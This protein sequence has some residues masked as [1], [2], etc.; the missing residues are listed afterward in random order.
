MYKTAVVD[1]QYLP[2]LEYFVCW[3]KYDSILIESQENFVKQTYRNRCHILSSN[4][5]LPLSIPVLGGN[6]K[7]RVKDIKIDYNQRW[8]NT[9]WRAIMSAYGRA[10]Y[11]E[12][13]ADYFESI[14]QKREKYLFDLNCQLLTL[15]LNLLGINKPLA[16]TQT[17][18]KIVDEHQKDLRSVIHPKKNYADNGFYKHVPYP[19]IF[20]KG[21]VQNLS[22]IDA[23]MC[24]GPETK[25]M[26]IS[27][28]K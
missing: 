22:I 11:F 7:T 14:F 18:K 3:L 27:S 15:C 1:L 24:I 23:L 21:F 4:K 12:F 5:V 25:L 8:L 16:F 19:Q 2:P 17:Y 9:H 28:S 6:S 20:G 26:L 13:Y 10:P